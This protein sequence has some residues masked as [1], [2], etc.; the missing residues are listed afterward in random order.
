MWLVNTYKQAVCRISGISARMSMDAVTGALSYL[1]SSKHNAE[2]AAGGL[3]HQSAKISKKYLP[4]RHLNE[5]YAND[6]SQ[7]GSHVKE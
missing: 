7:R 2:F 1:S 5:Q 3:C 6:L 4:E